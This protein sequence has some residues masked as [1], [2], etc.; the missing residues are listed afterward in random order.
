MC[1]HTR[2]W[3]HNFFCTGNFWK[4]HRN[5]CCAHFSKLSRIINIKPF[6]LLQT[7]PLIYVK[8]LV[9]LDAIHQ[10]KHLMRSAKLFPMHMFQLCGHAWR[11][12]F[13]IHC[14]SYNNRIF[15]WTFYFPEDVAPRMIVPFGNILRKLQ[16]PYRNRRLHKCCIFS[17]TAFCVSHKYEHSF[18]RVIFFVNSGI[19]SIFYVNFIIFCW[20]SDLT[21]VF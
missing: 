4:L 9:S 14:P 10:K 20:I 16:I 1:F 15:I 11:K 19:S 3:L 21:D 2:L 8:A 5:I 17:L 13:Y 7:I 18:L 6:F 12:A